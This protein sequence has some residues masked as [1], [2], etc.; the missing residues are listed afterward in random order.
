MSQY[1]EGLDYWPFSTGFFEDKKVKLIRSEFGFRGVMVFVYLLNEIYRDHG[2]YKVWD[3]DDCFLVSDSLGANSGCSP[4]FVEEVIK[5]FLRRSLF[6]QRV[7]EAF[8]VLTSAAIQRRFLRAVGN[9]REL[10]PFAREYLLLDVHSPK[11][12][13]EATLRRLA[14]FSVASTEITDSLTGKANSPTDLPQSKEEEVKKGENTIESGGAPSATSAENADSLTGNDDSP[15]GKDESSKG[16]NKPVRHK[17]GHY[18]RVLLS[19]EEL[20]RLKRDLGPDMTNLC[21]AFI[22]MRAEG[23]YKCKNWN[24]AIRNCYREQWFRNMPGWYRAYRETHPEVPP[25]NA[26][27][28]IRDTAAPAYQYNPGDTSGGLM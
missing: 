12:V 23:G 1:K 9:N 24:L 4:T 2:Y 16:K 3:K 28:P 11:D 8:H 21:I 17:W 6:D 18:K 13:T 20:D 7:F 26:I 25:L 10:I 5:G 27:P 15:T 22:D 14:F 19:D